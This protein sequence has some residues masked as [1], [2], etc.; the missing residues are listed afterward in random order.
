MSERSL[1]GHD[2]IASWSDREG[3]RLVLL[4]QIVAEE[5]DHRGS[6]AWEVLG[7]G[8]LEQHVRHNEDVLP[9]C[10]RYHDLPPERAR[11][12]RAEGRVRVNRF[13]VS[14]WTLPASDATFLVQLV[15]LAVDTAVSD[16]I[17]ALE[18]MYYGDLL[19]S[20]TGMAGFAGT[21]PHPTPKT[22]QMVIWP[23][24]DHRGDLSE[25]QIQRLVYRADLPARPEFTRIAR[26]DELNRRVGRGAACGPFVS[27]LW[28]QQDYIENCGFISALMAASA[29]AVIGDAQRELVAE[30]ARLDQVFGITHQDDSA[31]S[32]VQSSREAIMHANRLVTRTENRIATCIDGFST[33]M[34]LI[35]GLRT[36]SYHR[37]LFAALDAE[38]NR[39]TLERLLA[40]VKEMVRIEQELLAAA[41]DQAAEARSLRWT[42]SLGAATVLTLP[43]GL[44]FG[45]LGVSAS[46]VSADRSMFDSQYWPI[47]ALVGTAALVICVVHVTLFVVNRGRVLRR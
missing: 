31:V 23:D 39:E 24:D 2:W 32:S 45:F 20:A 38:Q 28:G 44:I 33:L 36:E 12:K 5:P 46:E 41:I 16:V 30:I 34:P 25:D 21:S 6:P 26:P 11:W 27:V 42:I 19:D 13:T 17:R 43:F 3:L 8:R 4:S 35:P 18:D 14:Q 22:H 7:F 29:S 15:D 10:Q 1:P 47:Y 40:R 9:R 37:A